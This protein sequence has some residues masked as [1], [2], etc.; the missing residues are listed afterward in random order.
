MLRATTVSW[1][2]LLSL[3]SSLPKAFP[4]LFQA[5]LGLH[6]KLLQ[7]RPLLRLENCDDAREQARP[8]ERRFGLHASHRLG[9]LVEYGFGLASERGF[10]EELPRLEQA[11]PQILVRV[12]LADHQLAD[13]L[14]LGVGEI[15]PPK[16][17]TER[18][19]G[20]SRSEFARGSVPPRPH[21]T[22]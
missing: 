6:M 1:L 20:T 3:S 9:E 17:V 13:R 7:L 8:S 12:T 16:H 14:S 2:L 21:P 10:L 22:L 11:H 18:P 19:G 5:R 4:T 15:E